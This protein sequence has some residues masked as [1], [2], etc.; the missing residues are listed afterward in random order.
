MSWWWRR[1]KE[2]KMEA[3]F[4]RELFTKVMVEEQVFLRESITKEDLIRIR[5]T[6][7][8]RNTTVRRRRRRRRRRRTR[9]LS[10]LKL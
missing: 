10:L 9:R 6:R 8:R 7:I 2:V 3:V 4:T 1:Q 5:P